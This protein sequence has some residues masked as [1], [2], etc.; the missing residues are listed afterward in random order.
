MEN[1]DIKYRLNSV[2][3]NFDFSISYNTNSLC[4]FD[5][6]KHYSYPATFIP[7]IPF[8]LIE[9][10]SKK[11]DI[12]LDPFGGIGTTFIQALLL[13]RQPFTCDINPIATNVCCGLYDIFSPDLDIELLK[14]QLLK[15]CD[16]YNENNDY[17]NDITEFQKNLSGWYAK[18][19]YNKLC[20]LIC[21]YN[22]LEDGVL[23][24][25]AQLVISSVL[26]TLSSQNK[27]WAYIADNVKPK[28]DEFKDKPVFD[29]FRT[30]VKILFT[31]VENHINN[32]S[33]SFSKFYFETKQIQRIFNNSVLES[34]IPSVDLIITSPP[35][36]KMIDYVKSQRMALCF[37]NEK[38]DD[39]TEQEIG[40]RCRRARK[41]TLEEYKAS[42]YTINKHLYDLLKPNGFFCLIL[43][44]YPDKDDRKMIID[45]M[46]KS[47][48]EFG[49]KT[50]DCFKRYIP[51]NRRTISIQWASLVNEKI[52]IFRKES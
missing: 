40:A 20:Y 38:Y 46:I 19:T 15:L 17:T 47:C 6:R 49:L 25:I 32:L 42:M 9:I 1:N 36:P 22:V 37:S 43:P 3:W 18:D 41:N 12:V 11:G 30:K 34:H 51:S 35:Y 45:D 48:E 39:F 21:S 14:Q 2:N 10:L 7:E 52:F 13:E 4:P 27:G 31:D 24:T 8:T 33:T 50:I 5:C 23:K 16:G 26:S 28:D 44:D 29:T